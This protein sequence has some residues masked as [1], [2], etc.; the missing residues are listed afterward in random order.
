MTTS[1]RTFEDPRLVPRSQDRDKNI[2]PVGRSLDDELEHGH[3][4]E[5]CGKAPAAA[6]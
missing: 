1:C 2:L 6:L 5:G 3:Q 4:P